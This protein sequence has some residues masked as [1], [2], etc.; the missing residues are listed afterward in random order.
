[1]KLTKK[2]R[3]QRVLRDRKWEKEIT[4]LTGDITIAAVLKVLRD[5]FG[6]GK[7]RI[8]RLLTK[9]QEQMVCMG[10]GYVCPYDIFEMLKREIDFDWRH[11][12]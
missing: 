7:V 1:M 12:G 2:L 10:E 6:W 11:E 8:I 5:E 4:T 3:N 9:M